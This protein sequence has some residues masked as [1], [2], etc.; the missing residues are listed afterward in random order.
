M[1]PSHTPS[2]TNSAAAQAPR[3]RIEY[4]AAYQ[5]VP[6]SPQWAINLLWGTVAFLSS[7]L[8]PIVGP[9]VWTGYLYEFT[10]SLVES[11]GQHDPD[12]DF[13]RFSNYITHGPWPFLFQLVL[14]AMAFFLSTALYVG[15]VVVLAV[16]AA[17]EEY[18][19][20]V[21]GILLPTMA[22]LALAAFLGAMVWLAPA[23]LRA[24]LGQEIRL[25]ICPGSTRDFFRRVG[26]RAGAHHAV[27]AGDG[28]AGFCGWLRA[29]R[30]GN[31]SGVGLGDDG[32]RSLK[33]SALCAIRGSRRCAGAVQIAGAAGDYLLVMYLPHVAGGRGWHSD[34]RPAGGH[35][36]VTPSHGSF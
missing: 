13:G 12:F 7:S 14:W 23:M 18:A 19:P 16:A 22:L 21:L 28:R 35:I 4:F 6:A 25:A 20:L 31:L 32:Q 8:L 5:F 9:M 26:G 30:R 24:G 15:I 36:C 11:G 17:G 3:E 2:A 1:S 34:P 29:S 27:S 10:E 33:L